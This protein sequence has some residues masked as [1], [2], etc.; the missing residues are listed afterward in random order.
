MDQDKGTSLVM[1][2]SDRG[3]SLFE[4]IKNNIVWR[5]FTLEDARKGNPALYSSLKSVKPD[6]SEFFRVLDEMPF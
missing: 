6:R 2:N 5:E 4:S 1:I 3:M